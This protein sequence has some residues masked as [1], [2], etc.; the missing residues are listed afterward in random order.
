MFCMRLLLLGLIALLSACGGGSGVRE[1]IFPPSASVQEL[2]V[3]TD[4]RW[5]LKLRLQNFSNV[6]MRID[7][8]AA[9]L[10]VAGQPAGRIEAQPGLDVPPESAEI[11][12]VVVTPASA[13]AAAVRAATDQRGNV[14]YAISGT[15]RSSEP[16]SRRD[17]F[18]FDSQLSA[19]PGLA[20]VL[21]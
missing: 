21:R 13:A 11:V 15:I 7:S 9:E 1:R 17:E 5:T 3:G 19:V 12:E 8:V 16:D 20:G 2:A 14:R 10:H 18:S 6:S 4:G